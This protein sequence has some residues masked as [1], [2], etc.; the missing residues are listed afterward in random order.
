MKKKLLKYLAFGLFALITLILVSATIVEKIYGSNFA[1]E[2]IYCSPWMVALWGISAHFAFFYIVRQKL[3]RQI[4]TFSIH[5]SFLLIITGAF[6]TYKY[7]I[8]GRL[9][10]REGDA[11]TKEYML[12]DAD[13]RQFPFSVAL[14]G[15]E[16]QYYEGTFAP[17]DYV[18]NIVIED[19][20]ERI[21]GRVSM[22]N[23]FKHRG[24]RFYQS[25]YD[26]DGKGTLLSV[27]YDPYGIG[28]TYTGYLFLLLSMLG[29]FLQPNSAFRKLLR[30]PALRRGTVVVAAIMCAMGASAAPRT[31][32][33]D[34]AEEFGNLHIYYNDR[35]C[36]LQTLA[37]DFTAK[38]YGKTSYKGLSAEQ[39]LTGWFFFYDDWKKEPIIK[40]K[41]SDVQ[42]AL[43]IGSPYASLTDFTDKNGYKLDKILQSEQMSSRRNAESANEKFNLVNM[44]CTGNILKIFPYNDGQTSPA[45]WYSLADKLP[46]SMP[47]EQWLFICNS[48]NM[49]AER[50]AM[51][52][53]VEVKTLLQKIRKYQI[54]ESK[55][56]L[57]GHWLFEAEKLYNT[58]NYNRLLA[59]SCLITSIVCFLMMVLWKEPSGRYKKKVSIPFRVIAW[60]AFIYITLRIALR[61]VISGYTPLSNGFE[62]MQFMAWCSMGMTILL[63]RRY[64]MALP[65]GLLLCGFTMLVAMMGEA[66]PKITQ[67][68]PVLQSP[69]LSIHVAVIMVSYTL[70]GFTMLNGVTAIVLRCIGRAN[71]GEIEHLYVVSRIMLYPAVFL[72][73]AGIFIGAVWANISWGRYWGWDPKEVWAL[74]TMMV[75]SAALHCSSLDRF[76]RPMF[77]HIFCIWAFLTVL[78]TYFGVNFFLGG[79]HSYA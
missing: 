2:Y 16:L 1:Q 54:R 61:G 24:Y 57:P 75:Y 39:V 40:I 47:Y 78:I 5:L 32:P 50:V 9:H 25:G 20:N 17:M 60:V 62:T 46:K 3:Y 23:I 43:G 67:L 8:Q 70:L 65:S 72:L 49:V 22:N 30:H 45:V 76:R 7:G 38:L 56:A 59:M 41:G 11:A 6:L 71:N 15:F 29:F 55:N 14:H 33:R 58:T 66:T 27:A 68:M 31:L 10:L 42:A 74:I 73:T 48:M 12:T 35:I 4:V 19:G 69:L 53:Y 64:S 21:E 26:K 28:I 77:F 79:M 37:R 51:K 52:D 63:G 13:T 44:L 34:V 36:P 18:S